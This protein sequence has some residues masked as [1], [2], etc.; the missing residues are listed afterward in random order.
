MELFAKDLKP[1]LMKKL[2]ALFLLGSLYAC[3]SKKAINI[4]DQMIANA[5]AHNGEWLTH[6]LNYAEDRFSLLD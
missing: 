5:T 4:D 1:L 2:L 6:G 3:S